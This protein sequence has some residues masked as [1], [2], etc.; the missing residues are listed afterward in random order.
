MRLIVQATHFRAGIFTLAENVVNADP[1]DDPGS[2]FLW[3]PAC[4]S[5]EGAYDDPQFFETSIVKNG[6]LKSYR[7]FLQ[8]FV[9]APAS[10]VIEVRAHYLDGALSEC[11]PLLLKDSFE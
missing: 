8:D 2:I 9:V 4:A 3:M 7:E 10:G 11:A 5:H 1:N 6:T